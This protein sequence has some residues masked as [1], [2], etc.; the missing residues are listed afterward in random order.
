ME[1]EW[2]TRMWYLPSPLDGFVLNVNFTHIFSKAQYPYTIAE[3]NGRAITYVDTSF[4]DRLL[5]QPDDVL[6]LSVGYDLG[7][8]SARL[9]MLHQGK[10]FTGVEFWPQLRS[11]TSAYTRWDLSVRQILPWFGLQLFGDIYNINNVDDVSVINGINANVPRL[12]QSYGMMA[13]LGL[14]IQF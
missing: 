14:R 10:V 5:F 9:S 7:G 3:R 6:N 11:W 8:F 13:D 4:T 2:Q 1:F 12:E